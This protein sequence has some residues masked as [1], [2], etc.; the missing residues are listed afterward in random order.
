MSVF[1]GRTLP[2]VQT[3]ASNQSI[4]DAECNICLQPM[5]D[6]HIQN[7]WRV[8]CTND[9]VLHRACLDE[10]ATRA[11]AACPLCREPLLGMPPQP[12]VPPPDVTPLNFRVGDDARILA[13]IA[14]ARHQLADLERRVQHLQAEIAAG[15]AGR[16]R[17]AARIFRP[18]HRA[19]ALELAGVE[20]EQ[21]L[22]NTRMEVEY[23]L[24]WIDMTQQQLH[25]AVFQDVDDAVKRAWTNEFMTRFITC[26]DMGH[27]MYD[28]K[29]RKAM[30]EI[31]EWADAGMLNPA[32][33]DDL[34][35]SLPVYV[36]RNDNMVARAASA[37]RVMLPDGTFGDNVVF[38]R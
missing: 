11:N 21:S 10:W 13:R 1:G 31:H 12:V 18:H 35:N 33:E 34:R 38:F 30:H 3:R 17:N 15:A 23:T 14:A 6:V 28:A 24:L 16:T 2:G 29:I 22:Q 7:N 25:A 20:L 4:A 37:R 32:Y 27:V 5:V 8:A 36:V 19:L 9:H 26:Q